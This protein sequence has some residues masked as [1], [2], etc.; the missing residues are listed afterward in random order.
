MVTEVEI[1]GQGFLRLDIPETVDGAETTLP[2][3]TQFYSPS[4]VYALTPTTEETARAVRSR[5]APVQAWE[6]PLRHRALVAG[7]SDDETEEFEREVEAAAM[8]EDGPF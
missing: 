2:A 5:P 3:A 4:S 1:A 6:V 8:A 7:V